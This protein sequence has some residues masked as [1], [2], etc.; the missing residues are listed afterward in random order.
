MCD[1]C[2]GVGEREIMQGE[3]QN[4]I[5]IRIIIIMPIIIPDPELRSSGRRGRGSGEA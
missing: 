1:A 3:C 5:I 2:V 4:I